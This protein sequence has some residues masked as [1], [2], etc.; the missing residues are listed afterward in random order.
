VAHLVVPLAPSD[1]DFAPKVDVLLANPLRLLGLVEAKKINLG[2]VR[3][4]VLD[5]ADKLFE[6]GFMEQVGC[7]E[8]DLDHFQEMALG[9]RGQPC[10]FSKSLT[11]PLS[12]ILLQI[13]GI[14]AACN[15]KDIV[16]SLFSAT[17]PEKVEELAR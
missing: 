5:E 12:L 4:L 3:F 17:L 1:T 16:R 6:L 2:E 9:T 7:Q 14:I 8:E 15:H 11:L 10:D 13:D